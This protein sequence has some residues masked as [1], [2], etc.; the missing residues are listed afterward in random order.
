MIIDELRRAGI[1]VHHDLASDS[2]SAQL[3]D[4]EE[5]G[6][7]YTIIIGQKEYVE[8]SVILRDLQERSQ[9]QIP[10]DQMVKKLRRQNSAART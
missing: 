8:K 4:A 9:E 10:I 6:M 1:N 7:R 3:R 2:L 5:R